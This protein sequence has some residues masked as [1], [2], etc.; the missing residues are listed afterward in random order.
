MTE[1]YVD[2]FLHTLIKKDR[3]ECY[4]LTL[5]FKKSNN[6]C[7]KRKKKIKSL[8]DIPKPYLPIN[9]HFYGFICDVPLLVYLPPTPSSN[10]IC[11][12]NLQLQE[13]RF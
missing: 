12:G 5:E 3:K 2:C 11:Y 13:F 8:I 1:T 10:F 6:P 4:K 7:S 9:F